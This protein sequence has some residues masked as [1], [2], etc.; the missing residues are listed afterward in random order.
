VLTPA[1]L[2]AEVIRARIAVIAINEFTDT[3]SLFTMIGLGTGII[4]HTLATR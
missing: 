4:I 1:Q 3:D 2:G